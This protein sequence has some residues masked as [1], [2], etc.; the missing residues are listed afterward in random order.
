MG[1]RWPDRD[2]RPGLPR[3]VAAQRREYQPLGHRWPVRGDRADGTA[4]LVHAGT[5][6]LITALTLEG[7]RPGYPIRVDGLASAPTFGPDGR[8]FVTVE[9]TDASTGDAVTDSNSQVV[10]FTRDG[11]IARGWPADVP[12][13]TWTRSGDGGAMAERPIAAPDGSVYVVFQAP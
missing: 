1:R 2:P 5:D 10:A 13:D 7:L 3:R 4:Y 6:S 12:F 11:R 9:A 8:L